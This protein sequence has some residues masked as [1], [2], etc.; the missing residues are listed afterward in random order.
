MII[1]QVRMKFR[2]S[3]EIYIGKSVINEHG[4]PKLNQDYVNK[5]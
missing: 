3:L 5:H 1:Q 4:L 2:P